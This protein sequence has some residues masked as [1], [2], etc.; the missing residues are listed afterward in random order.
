MKKKTASSSSQAQL[1]GFKP[2]EPA[3]GEEYM[4][5]KQREHFRQILLAWRQELMEEADRTMHHLQDEQANLPDPAD[6][7][8]QEEE[9]ALELRTR[10][11]ER[12][13]LKKI[14]K[15][16]DLVDKDDYGFCEACGIE[17]GIRR[18]EARPTAELCID[19]KELAE[20]KEKQLAG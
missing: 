16:L 8:T 7:A 12:K 11:R 13:L 18:L 17:I 1:H 15:T 3:K 9:F 10:D 5:E 2:Y 14:E 6:R 20:I 4:N 19:C